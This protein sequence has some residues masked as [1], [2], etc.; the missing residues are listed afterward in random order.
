MRESAGEGLW[1][2]A[3]VT[4]GRLHVTCGMSHVTCD[5]WHI[6]HDF[7]FTKSDK[8]CQKSHTKMSKKSIELLSTHAKT[9]SVSRMRN[10]LVLYIY[11]FIFLQKKNYMCHVT[12]DM[13]HMTY[14]MWHVTH[15]VSCVMC[16]VSHVTWHMTCDMWHM[17]HDT[18]YVVC[19]EHSQKNLAPELLQF[20]CKGNWIKKNAA[21]IRVLSKPGLTPPGILCHDLI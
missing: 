7:S 17:T 20:V 8:N 15:N 6:K 13:W 11:I 10:F 12:C 21:L 9:A 5:S 1:L 19:G 2:L 14:D 16:H 18:W 4:G 3:I